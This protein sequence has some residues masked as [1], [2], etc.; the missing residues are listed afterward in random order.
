MRLSFR[1]VTTEKTAV[2]IGSGALA[3]TDRLI[4]SLRPS[5]IFIL[6]D[7]NT[8]RYCLPILLA[9]CPALAGARLLQVLPGGEQAKT[10]DQAG[11]LWEELMTAGAERNSLLINL[12]GGVTSDLGGFAAAGFKRGIRYINVPTSLIGMAD[13]ALGGKTAVNA[14]KLKNQAGFF[15]CPVAVLIYPPFLETLPREHLR[16][17][18]AEIIKSSLVGDAGLYHYILKNSID[19]WLALSVA[20][21]EW[22][23]LLKQTVRIK[24]RLASQDYREHG[25]RK[26]LN[27]GHTIGHG[28]EALSLRTDEI[29]CLHGEAVAAGM[30]GATR[31][32]AIKAGL[33]E[34]S[35]DEIERYLLTGFPFRPIREATLP[36]LWE[37]LLQDKK[38]SGGAVRFTLLR[39]PGRPHLN[40][41]CSREEVFGAIR[42]FND[43]VR[44]AAA[45]PDFRS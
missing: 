45:N 18:L 5:G 10:L 37:A 41:S 34:Q 2:F 25:I 4:R 20:G 7:R 28:V 1:T 33:G 40:M 6:A 42:Y 3:E 38:V 36:D 9:A 19:C 44:E 17:G 32:S 30:I 8:E 31:L 22:E 39:A 29:P 24:T 26:A 43:R 23:Y 16:S 13:A 12:G 35:A 15:Y 27:F 21:K 11:R 14:G